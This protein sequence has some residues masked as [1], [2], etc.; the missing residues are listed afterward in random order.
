VSA[1]A[2]ALEAIRGAQ[3]ARELL[4]ELRTGTAA[5]DALL[6]AIGALQAPRSGASPSL[7]TFARELQKALEISAPAY[8]STHAAAATQV[9]STHA[10]ERN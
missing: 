8:A 2:T 5:P 1:A 7:R 3:W 10:G 6:E 4:D 9:R